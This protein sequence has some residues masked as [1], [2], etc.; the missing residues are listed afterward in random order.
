M[1]QCLRTDPAAS[2]SNAGSF[3][4]RVDA[5]EI[6]AIQVDLAIAVVGPHVPAE[7]QG[8]PLTAPYPSKSGTTAM[9]LWEA[10]ILATPVTMTGTAPVVSAWRSRRSFP[11]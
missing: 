4:P 10:V 6:A 2:G 8:V 5:L 7:A 1:L 11:S 9:M 3:L